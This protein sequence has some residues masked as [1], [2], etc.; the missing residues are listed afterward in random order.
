MKP[1]VLK[2]KDSIIIL[3]PSGRVDEEKVREKPDHYFWFH[4]KWKTLKII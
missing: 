2:K 4:R 3:S 1:V